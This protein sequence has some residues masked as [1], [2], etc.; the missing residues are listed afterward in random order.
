MKYILRACSWDAVTIIYIEVRVLNRSLR[1]VVIGGDGDGGP[2]MLC[3]P[4]F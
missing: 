2:E 1:C 4:M 3:V